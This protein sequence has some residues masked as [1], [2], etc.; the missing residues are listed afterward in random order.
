MTKQQCQSIT[1]GTDT[2]LSIQQNIRE[3]PLLSPCVLQTG[4]F[5][6][7]KVLS[8]Q[9][10]QLFSLPLCF[11][12]SRSESSEISPCCILLLLL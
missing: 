4:H 2:S 9:D 10:K 3:D 5:V 8:L 7:N 1:L 11:D 6:L 12:A